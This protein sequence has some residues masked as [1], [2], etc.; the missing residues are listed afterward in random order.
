M[1]AAEDGLLVHGIVRNGWVERWLRSLRAGTSESSFELVENGALA[2]AVTPAAFPGPEEPT[3]EER[4]RHRQVVSELMT[5]RSV[6]P[7]PCG[8][9][10][11]N[12][13]AVSRLLEGQRVA[14][15]EALEYLENAVEL[16]LY[17]RPSVVPVETDGPAP[18]SRG[19]GPQEGEDAAT[20]SEEVAGTSEFLTRVLRVLRAHARSTRRLDVGPDGTARAAF[21]VSRDEW[22]HFARRVERCGSRRPDLSLQLEGPRPPYDFV[23]LVEAARV[24]A[25][26]ARPDGA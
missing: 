3:V 13:P 25:P 15:E 17:V 11:R 4:D 8:F 22:E 21:L 12:A 20:T 14:L 7:F 16:L 9:R 10:A 6:V 26:A 24:R 18:P 5:R 2:A 23:R 1:G 19:A